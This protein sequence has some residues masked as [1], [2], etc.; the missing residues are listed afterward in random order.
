MV[1]PED[2]FLTERRIWGYHFNNESLLIETTLLVEDPSE[3]STFQI[4]VVFRSGNTTVLVECELSDDYLLSCPDSNF[5]CG[6]FIVRF[7]STT[8]ADNYEEKSML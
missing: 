2:Q 1:M 6:N 8:R 7:N 3:I 4:N 5:E